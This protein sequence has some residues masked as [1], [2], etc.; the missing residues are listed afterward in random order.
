[1]FTYKNEIPEGMEDI[2]REKRRKMRKVEESLRDHFFLNGY[3]EVQTP[4]FE[5]YDVFASLGGELEQDR[6]V[7]FLD[8]RGSIL[9]LRPDMTTPIARMVATKMTQEVFPLRLC[10]ISNIFRVDSPNSGR[11]REFTQGGIELLGV[12]GPRGDG[13]VIALGIKALLSQG[14]A[15]FQ[16][17]VG[18]NGFFKALT[19]NLNLTSDE[20]NNL[21]KIID[22]KNM[23]AL[24]EFIDGFDW[25]KKIK[26]LIEALP[27]LFGK[28]EKVL[29]DLK[30]Y[31]INSVMEREIEKLEETLEVVKDYGVEEYIALDFGLVSKMN[32]YSG[33]IFRG[34][35]KDVGYTVLSGGRYDNLVGNFGFDCPATGFAIDVNRLVKAME[36][37][38]IFK[39]EPSIDYSLIVPEDFRREA[40]KLAESLR[41]GRLSVELLMDSENVVD[42]NSSFIVYFE[43]IDK[44]KVINS[45]NSIAKVENL[46]DFTDRLQGEERKR[47]AS[48]H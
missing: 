17:D 3:R 11:E 2:L 32:Y 5:Y 37:Q 43:S 18:H 26:E 40:F 46:S 21:Q 19:D 39:E 12:E 41:S 45:R 15:G 14:I 16:I 36:K 33:L 13:E 44:L 34:L 24:K 25:D 29:K 30:G 47:E 6:M 35:I 38:D 28:P 42:G 9:V 23:V 22:G 10:Y 8:P 7:K 4:T 1:M 27:F 48:R 20:K 31:K